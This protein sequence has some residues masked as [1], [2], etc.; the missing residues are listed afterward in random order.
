M[1]GLL[2]SFMEVRL[3][4]PLIAAAAPPAGERGNKKTTIAAARAP[5]PLV[6]GPNGFDC[7]SR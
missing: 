3:A 1:D 7:R 2:M 5:S 4:V 6:A